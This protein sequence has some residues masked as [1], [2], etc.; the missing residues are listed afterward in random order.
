[1]TE[2][3]WLTVGVPTRDRPHQLADLLALIAG[4]A[5]QLRR[6]WR[7]QVLVADGTAVPGTV[8]AALAA[9]VEHAQV[10][11]VD[12]GVSTGR[13]LLA[14]HALGDVLVLVDDDV[15]PHSGS[16]AVL[17]AA[18][19]SG[20]AV[21]GRVCGLGHRNDEPSV[22]MHLGRKGFG[23]PAEPGRPA[24]YL[25][26][27]LLALPRDVYTTVRWDE[28]FAAAHLDDVMFGLRLRAAGVVLRECSAATA[29][30]PDRTEK[31][32]PELAGHRALVVVTRWSG[33]R[34]ATVWLR[35]LAHLAWTHR[36]SPRDLTLA[37][38]HYA[39]AT[40]AWRVAR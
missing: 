9:A 16:L 5:P 39:G 18:T 2:R 35:C 14:D 30:H 17:A 15:R 23:E 37:V 27:A 6:H 25:V 24:D 31:D 19:S 12:G 21:A 8:P 7:V 28:R 13:N 10:L 29:D 26:S 11:P 3:P 1:M 22:P 33:Q 40:W 32:A 36:R 38:S 4:Q 20:T 34:L